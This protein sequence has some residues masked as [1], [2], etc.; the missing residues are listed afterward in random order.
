MFFLGFWLISAPFHFPEVDSLHIILT[1]IFGKLKQIVLSFEFS[2]L[3]RTM[4]SENKC[5]FNGLFRQREKIQRWCW[6]FF[7]GVF[8][9]ILIVHYFSYFLF[10]CY[11]YT[12]TFQIV[13]LPNLRNRF[14]NNDRILLKYLIQTSKS[15]YAVSALL[16]LFWNVLHR[17]QLDSIENFLGNTQ[18]WLSSFLFVFAAFQN[19]KYLPSF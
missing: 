10:I 4:L 16:S 19:R 5:I 18:H 12:S 15:H 6:H 14:M 13:Y 7:W 8:V 17:Y 2:S 11:L 1:G 9:W 3:D